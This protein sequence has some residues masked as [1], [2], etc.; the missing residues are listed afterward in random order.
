MIIAEISVAP[1]G[2]GTSLSSYVKHA[3]TAIKNANVKYHTGPMS[4]S[5]EAENLDQLFAVVKA[6]HEAV[7]NAGAPRVLTTLKIDDRRDKDAHMDHKV[8]AIE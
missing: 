8:K 4:T 7:L 2:V 6:A 3:H 5:F 1:V